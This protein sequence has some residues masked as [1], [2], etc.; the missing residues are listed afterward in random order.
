MCGVFV[1]ESPTANECF[2]HKYACIAHN[3]PYK[4]DVDIYYIKKMCQT[5]VKAR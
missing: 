5:I 4:Q 2:H 1:S 3:E